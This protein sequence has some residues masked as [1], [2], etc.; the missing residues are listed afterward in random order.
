VRISIWQQFSSNHSAAYTVVG[1]FETEENARA[2][3][4][5][6]E[7]ALQKIDKWW[8]TLSLEE[9]TLWG[10]KAE[11]PHL[12]PPEIELKNQYK[13]DWPFSIHWERDKRFINVFRNFLVIGSPHPFI[14][15]GP[16]PF[17]GL[18]TRLGGTP[19]IMASESRN[20]PDTLLFAD[21]TCAAP[22]ENVAQ[23]IASSV[24]NYY[25]DPEGMPIPWIAYH[26]GT[27]DQRAEELKRIE[28]QALHDWPIKEQVRQKNQDLE[29]R[30]MRARVQRNEAL[31]TVLQNEY[32]EE[33]KAALGGREPIDWKEFGWVL[34]AM[35][36]T[37]LDDYEWE[38]PDSKLN[39]VHNKNYLNFTGLHFENWF[40]G[41]KA[42]YAWLE[43]LGCTEITYSF[44]DMKDT[45]PKYRE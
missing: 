36:K 14:W 4:T 22:N 5:M 31:R 13:V 17:N 10:G 19:S 18:I 44:W 9:R 40:T 29:I 27:L 8:E 12:T 38:F 28:A 15:Y 43:A 42:L 33:V 39:V 16:Q 2:A 30:I 7:V 45:R 20:Y 35:A 34:E 3:A 1:T 24:K 37:R 41:I 21:L 23:M 11:T 26:S 6:I 25:S 32:D